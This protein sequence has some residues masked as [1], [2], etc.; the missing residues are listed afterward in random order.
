MKKIKKHK[1]FLIISILCM[2]ISIN[3]FSAEKYILNINF[4]NREEFLNTIKNNELKNPKF[5]TRVELGDGWHSGELTI[6][7][8]FFPVE[9]TCITEEMFP[10]STFPSYVAEHG[11]YTDK[12]GKV[13]FILSI[14]SFICSF[15]LKKIFI[16]KS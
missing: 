6:F 10:K 7:Y 13:F 2:F 8:F 9:R 5:I 3:F 16:R 12:F 11:I 1:L 4:F 15:I 14:I